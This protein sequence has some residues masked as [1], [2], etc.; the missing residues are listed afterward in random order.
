MATSLFIYGIDRMTVTVVLNK[1]TIKSRGHLIA[2]VFSV[3]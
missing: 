1:M 2:D 3:F